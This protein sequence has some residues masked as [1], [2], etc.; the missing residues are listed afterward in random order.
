MIEQYIQ[1]VIDGGNLS[2][3]EAEEAMDAIMSGQVTEAQIGGYLTALRMKGETIEEITGS[4]K[5][6]REK[7]LQLYSKE[8][9]MDI[10]GTGGDCSN[11][12]NV[13]TASAFVVAAAGIKVAKH[14][15]RSVSSK[16]GSADVLE[17]LGVKLDLT[18]EQNEAVLEKTGICFMFAPVYHSAM[19]YV[20]RPRKEL[21]VRTIFNILGPLANPAYASL[22]LMGVYSEALVEPMAK[23]LRNLGVTN[24]LVV[25]GLDGVDEVSICGKTKVSEIR[26]SQIINYTIDP[27]ALGFKLAQIDEIKGGDALENKAIMLD[28]L[29]GK[30]GAKRDMVIINSA[31]ALS[32]ALR[33]KS[34]EECVRLA[35]RL[36]DEGKAK[37][38]L[39]E[40]VAA[41]HAYE[42]TQ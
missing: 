4:A 27:E 3:L 41:T 16:C 1:R 7:C 30:K 22:Q 39:E 19:K 24:A 9:L 31:A 26:D 20:A 10:V 40:L 29:N 36:I 8:T 17:A 34:L 13:S 42:V 6:M 5:V 2:T 12:F 25:H 37:A 18:K 14:G 35:E 15:N 11:T 32:V 23:V 21:G 28:I 33:D 38:K